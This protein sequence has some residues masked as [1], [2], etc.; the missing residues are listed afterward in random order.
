MLTILIVI[1]IVW[2]L[3]WFR[4]CYINDVLQQESLELMET[5]TFLLKDK[6]K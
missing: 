1:N 2:A 6:I 4:Q 3:L 5:V